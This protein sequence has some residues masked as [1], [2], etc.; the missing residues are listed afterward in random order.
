MKTE[1]KNNQLSR[2]EFIKKIGICGTTFY[3]G[4]GG[5]F[6]LAEKKPSKKI[7]NNFD[8]QYRTVSVKHLA[9]LKEWI[10]K[11]KTDGKVSNN[12]NYL[13]YIG[14]FNF[15][16]K[17][18]LPSAKSIIVMTTQLGVSS[19]I[20]NTKGKKYKII[21]PSGYVDDGITLEKITSRLYSDIIKD[22]KKKL[23][24]TKLPVKSIAVRSGLATYGKNNISFVN[25]YGSFHSPATFLTDMELEDNW[26]P[27]KML[28][29]C[30]GCS[31]CIKSCPTNVIKEDKFV[32]NVDKCIPLYN[33]RLDPL[34]D[35][36]EPKI[37]DAL[38]GC[39][40]CQFPCPA[41]IDGMNNI[42]NIGEL[43]EEETDFILGAEGLKDIKGRDKEMHERIIKKLSRFSY[44][45]Y[46]SYFSR[47]LKLIIANT[48]PV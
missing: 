21:I 48:K 3:L 41:N 40:Q 43:N 27:Y 32:I 17:K 30:K 12:K 9:E 10:D 33:E 37:V 20:F 36:F 28:R 5:I 22:K 25:K 1:K 15:D 7:L 42:E 35:W 8:Y 26:G 4:M 13:K 19:I 44:V 31:I 23:I 47:N 38:A 11:L 16:Y 14:N 34:P 29:E 46:L 18:V 2:R 45:K 24:Y 39:G 6:T